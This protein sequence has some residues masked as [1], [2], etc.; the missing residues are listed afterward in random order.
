MLVTNGKKITNFP[1][2]ADELEKMGA[3]LKK[4]AKDVLGV[5]IKFEFKD[6][7][8]PYLELDEKTHLTYQELRQLC[9]PDIDL[10]LRGFGNERIQ[11][12]ETKTKDIKYVFTDDEKRDLADKFCNAQYDLE[13]VSQEA[14]SVAKTYKSKIDNLETE[15]SELSAKHRQGY[16]I[17]TIETNLHLDFESNLRIYTDKETGDIVHQEP[18]EAKDKQLKIEFV[19]GQL[20]EETFVE[21]TNNENIA[22]G[23]PFEQE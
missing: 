16:E 4:R 19:N 23:D 9:V 6:E 17:R 12:P 8:F 5:K 22:D 7:P 14:K 18:L 10:Q 1:T 21:E 13:Q 3:E 11:M 2:N 15:I 20:D